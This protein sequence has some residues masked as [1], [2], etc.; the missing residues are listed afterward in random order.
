MMSK[1]QWLVLFCLFVVYI[2]LGAT[3]FYHFESQKEMEEMQAMNEERKKIEG[4]F[5]VFYINGVNL[6]H[7]NVSSILR[8]YSYT[9]RI[10]IFKICCL[11]LRLC[12]IIS[13]SK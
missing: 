9:Q 5:Y 6:K 3:F 11:L 1:K 8:E 12:Y 13:H 7:T 4:N 10:I 2:L